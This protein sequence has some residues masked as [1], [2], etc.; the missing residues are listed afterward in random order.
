MAE[1]PWKFESSRPHHITPLKTAVRG[2]TVGVMSPE[3]GADGR[4]PQPAAARLRLL[5]LPRAGHR[6][7][8]R[9]RAC[10]CCPPQLAPY[11]WNAILGWLVTIAGASASPSSSPASPAASRAPA[12]PM[13]I[14]AEAFGAR[15]RLRRRVELLDLGLGRQRRHRARRR[16]L[17]Q[18]LRCPASSAAH[19]GPLAAIGFVLLF[20][21]INCLSVRRRRA[22]SSWRRRSSS[23]CRS[24][25][26]SRSRAGSLGAAMA[27]PRAASPTGDISLAAVAAD[28]GPDL[29]GDGRLRIGDHARPATSAIRER[30]IPRA[31][32]IGTFAGRPHL[33]A[34]L[35]G[36]WPCFCRR[37][38]AAASNAPFADFIGRYWGPGPASSRRL[39]RGDQRAGRAQRLG[40]DPGRDAAGAGPR[41][42]LPGLARAGLDQA[43]TPVARPPRLERPRHAAPARQPE[44]L[45]GRPVR[46]HGP[47]VDRGVAGRLSQLL[48]RRAS[49]AAR[50]AGCSASAGLAAVAIG[51][52][53]YSAWAILRGRPRAGLLGRGPA[54]ERPSRLHCDATK[55]V[56]GPDR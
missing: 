39:V 8:D 15:A 42:G 3:E 31:T 55:P 19:A 27:R 25:R 30:T 40:A 17:S 46:L 2:T 12:G 52:A 32:M 33:P 35:L 7:H 50:P 54:A 21:L 11:G 18:P 24:P 38:Q 6:Q 37:T 29:V 47:A 43:G 53:L 9:H 56:A 44:P 48:A 28:R 34:R 26:S 36:R 5:D 23:C 4:T 1:R 41:R 45:D 51:G 14:S 16:Q 20:T 49:A 13:P 10:S 22:R